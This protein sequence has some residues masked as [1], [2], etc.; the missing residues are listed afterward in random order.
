VLRHFGSHSGDVGAPEAGLILK[1]TGKLFG[2]AVLDENADV[3]GALRDYA[4]EIMPWSRFRL[5]TRFIL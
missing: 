1:R 5:T 3:G 2:T 4:Y